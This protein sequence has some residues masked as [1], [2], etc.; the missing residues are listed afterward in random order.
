[1][2]G[3]HP[4]LLS[5]AFLLLFGLAVAGESLRLPLGSLAESGPGLFPLALGMLLAG[6][7]VL[8]LV[9]GRGGGAFPGTGRGKPGK[10]L[11]VLGACLFLLLVLEHLGFRL[12]MI[13][14]LGFLL[15]WVERRPLW[16]AA[17]LAVSISWGTFY[18]FHALLQVRLPTGP[19]VF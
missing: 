12:A 19:W 4:D 13:A 3:W 18:L 8:L 6:L 15:G 1:M 17:G 5:G 10:I 16:L 7:S 11:Q 9:Q 14:F 2:K